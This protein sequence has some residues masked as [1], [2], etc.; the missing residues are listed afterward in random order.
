MHLLMGG[1]KAQLQVLEVLKQT[2]INTAVSLRAE[3][4]GTEGQR[5]HV[6]RATHPLLVQQPQPL[7]LTSEWPRPA[8]LLALSLLQRFLPA[9]LPSPVPRKVRACGRHLPLPLPTQV[10]V[11][12]GLPGPD[13]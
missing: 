8:A 13:V 11:V 9:G 3:V 5:W 6:P 7:S 4:V 12:A 2:Q 1:W 10:Q